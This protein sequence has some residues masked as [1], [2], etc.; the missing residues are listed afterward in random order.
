MKVG[1]YAVRD[2]KADAFMQIMSFANDGV[3]S[4][5]FG[6]AVANKDSFLARSPADYALYRLG[7][8]DET[9]GEIESQLPSMVCTA[10]SFISLS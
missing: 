4:R 9:S 8:V 10:M 3:A 7:S 1:I 5:E 6:F 2:V